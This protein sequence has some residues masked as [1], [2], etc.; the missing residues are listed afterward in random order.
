VSPFG[1]TRTSD[2]VRTLVAF[3]GKQTRCRHRGDPD[4]VGRLCSGGSDFDLFRYGKSIIDFDAK[5]AHRTLDLCVAKQE[6]N[7]SEIARTPIDQGRLGSPKGVGAEKVRV[8]PDVGNPLGDE[9]GILSRCYTPTRATPGG[10]H[11]FAGL[12]AGGP[13]VVIDCL[14]SLLRQFEP[15]WLPGLL[16]GARLP[17]QLSI[18][19]EQHPRP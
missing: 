5:V 11:K 19:S 12:L 15:D 16:F 7:G 8:Q 17:D 10:E 3:R 1:T 14:S 4:R 13:E 6:L 18:R 2:D 9:P